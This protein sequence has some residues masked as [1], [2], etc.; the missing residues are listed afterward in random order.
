MRVALRCLARSKPAQQSCGE[1]VPIC[2]QVNCYN[3]SAPPTPS[4]RASPS[5]AGLPKPERSV[6]RASQPSTSW[7]SSSA[8]PARRF[9]AATI[10]PAYSCAALQEAVTSS[11][12][13]SAVSPSLQELESSIGQLSTA[14]TVRRG[15]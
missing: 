1:I 6:V 5:P 14:S 4:P 12:S 3:H 13:A 8:L 10:G 7:R 11:D 2:A 9:S 15:A